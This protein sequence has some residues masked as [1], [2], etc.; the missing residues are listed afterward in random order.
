M[1]IKQRLNIMQMLIEQATGDPPFG[2]DLPIRNGVLL[3][4]MA[5]VTDAPFRRLAWRL[6]AGLVVSEMTASDALAQGGAQAMLRAETAETGPGV[7]QLAGREPRWMAEGA[8]VAEGSGAEMIDINMGCPARKVTNGYSGAALMRD[9]DHAARLIEATVGAVAVPVTLKMRLGW[10]DEHRNAPA[11]A[12][13]AEALGVRLVAVHGRTR[14]QFYTGTA[15]WNAVRAV[16]DAV[17]IP[18]VVNGDIVDDATARTALDRSGADGVMVGRAALG[19]PWLPGEIARALDGGGHLG[20]PPVAEQH[21]L[22]RELYD[23]LLSHHGVAVGVRYARKHLRAAVEAAFG[24][25]QAL[26]PAQKAERQVLLTADE[27]AAVVRAMDA[28][29]AVAA[30]EKAA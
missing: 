10:D 22:L 24:D 29:F 3:A 21:A 27:P 30:L 9:L 2:A 25:G 6:G 28:L 12:R 16:K 7:V 18:V 20:A 26:P 15:D 1:H 5:G 11:L 13:R 4:P 19:R 8:R 23:G 14:N 17:R